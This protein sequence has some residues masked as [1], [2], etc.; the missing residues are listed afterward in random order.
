MVRRVDAIFTKGAFRP[1]EPVALPE[2]MKVRLS[3]EEDSDAT[4]MPQAPAIHTPKLANPGDA[5]DFVLE[6]TET[7]DAGV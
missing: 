2:G 6:V 1:I 4:R 3:V 5:A 7:R